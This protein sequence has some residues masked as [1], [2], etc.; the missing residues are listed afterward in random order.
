ML[1]LAAAV[2]VL[3][4][5]LVDLV[6]AR[7]RSW[8]RHRDMVMLMVMAIIRSMHCYI[9][10]CSPV[11]ICPRLSNNI[12]YCSSSSYNSNCSI[13]NNNN[14][15]INIISIHLKYSS[16]NSS[17]IN[18]INS[19]SWQPRY[20]RLHQQQQQQQQRRRNSCNNHLDP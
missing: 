3:A 12:R 10:A 8:E 5:V 14:N 9:Q 18:Y 7:E 17:S 19:I 13:N 4:V 6:E 16:I 1:L 2:V 20:Q 15:S 11:D